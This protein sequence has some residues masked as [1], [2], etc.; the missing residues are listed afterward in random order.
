MKLVK[1]KHEA[2]LI[3]FF[4]LVFVFGCDSDK[5]KDSAILS[6]PTLTSDAA[7]S[8]PVTDEAGIIG[9]ESILE[10]KSKVMDKTL[11]PAALLA[12][13]LGFAWAGGNRLEDKGLVGEG[14]KRTKNGWKAEYDKN[15]AGGTK[16]H[17]RLEI[18]Y[19]DWNFSIKKI[20][21][22]ESAI[23]KV[24]QVETRKQNFDNF[25]GP[26][27]IIGKFNMSIVDSVGVEDLRS[28]TFGWSGG[29]T[30]SQD[31]KVP[32]LGGMSVELKFGTSGSETE[33]QTNSKTELKQ[34]DTTAFFTLPKFSKQE[35]IGV[36]TRTVS[37]IKY[38]ALIEAKFTVEFRG[39]MRWRASGG[40]YHEDHRGSDKRRRIPYKFG[41][42]T[43]SGM[44]SFVQELVDQSKN[45][46]SPWLWSDLL[47]DVPSVQGVI[48]RLS[49]PLAYTFPING[50]IRNV[51]GVEMNVKL[52]G[53]TYNEAAYEELGEELPVS[54]P[55]L[56]VANQSCDMSSVEFQK[57]FCLDEV[58]D[59]NGACCFET[60]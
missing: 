33:Q 59:T 52:G 3:S 15:G 60:M 5:D 46:I 31:V 18:I 51:K 30:M 56:D 42:I 9:A 49:D 44:T 8:E 34:F 57:D 37:T 19:S 26:K 16:A 45:D 39:F 53:V 22:G 36:A 27:D 28:Q 12:H 21:F 50:T 2:L 43:E 23:D 40:N 35:V 25:L 14:F 54:A 4:S 7:D 20:H 41:G 47:K 13:H 55:T 10:V 24:E 32:I 1:L 38:T 11:K 29:V 48:N 58:F 6:G 17:D